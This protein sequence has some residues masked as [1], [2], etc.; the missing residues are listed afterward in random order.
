MSLIQKIKQ[1]G[2]PEKPFEEVSLKVTVTDF[3]AG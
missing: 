1:I 2:V 3:R